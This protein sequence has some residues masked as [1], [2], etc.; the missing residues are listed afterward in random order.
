MI[1]FRVR[2]PEEELMYGKMRSGYL[3]VVITLREGGDET[4]RGDILD[5]Y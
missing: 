2:L 4:G 1:V 5:E 3:G